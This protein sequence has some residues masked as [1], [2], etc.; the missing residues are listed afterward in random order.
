[1]E[2]R[3]IL[4]V[5]FLCFKL[6]FAQHKYPQNYF[7][8]PLEV[9]LLLS[10]TFGEMRSNH[11]HAGLDIKTKQREGLKVL[12]AAKGYVSRIK[13][14][15]WGYGKVIYVDHPNGYTTVYAH[16]QKFS[17]KVEEYIKKK[18]YE[19]KSY[20][21]ELYPEAHELDLEQGELL[22]YSGKTGGF[23][24]PHLHFEIRDTK[25][26]RPINPLLFG[27]KIKDTIRPTIKGAFAYPISENSHINGFTSKKK[28]KIT[29]AGIGKLKSQKI[30]A[31]DTIG[32]G[33]HVIDLLNNSLNKNGIYSLEMKVNGKRKYYYEVESFSFDKTRKINL[34][35][36]YH[37]F[38]NKKEFVQKCFIEHNNDLSIYKFLEN[39]GQIEILDG[40]DYKIELVA[41]DYAGNTST[42]TIPVKGERK[43]IQ[44]KAKD[45]SDHTFVETSCNTTIQE[46]IATVIFPKETFYDNANIKV[47]QKD[48]FVDVHQ[49]IIPLQKK[50]TVAFDIR[51]KKE[52]ERKGL[53]IGRITGKKYTVYQNSIQNDTAI[54]AKTKYLGKYKLIKDTIPPKVSLKNFK[55]GQWITKY[56]FLKVKISDPKS[57]IKSYYPT[58]DG[59]WIRME[60]DLRTGVL[61]Y[62]LSDKEFKKAK[63]ELKVVVEDNAGNKS[64]LKATFYRKK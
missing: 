5:L 32:V 36:D 42:L 61:T 44:K 4:L 56:H 59:E 60:R 21:I 25:S 53:Y 28:L 46:G 31:I 27:Y 9:P 38:K 45:F 64:T 62:R 8:S 19:Q 18:Q 16:L 26:E 34:H 50:Y 1:M 13:I 43:N 52:S 24:P 22:A 47:T 49:D 23:I 10:G 58:I 2:K 30:T 20:E 14:S 11:F 12:A 29:N 6:S 51:D 63:H 57:G 15:M 48:N 40:L 3:I 39:A 17:P 35:L 37:H 41:K 55:D 33:I 54:F 7:K